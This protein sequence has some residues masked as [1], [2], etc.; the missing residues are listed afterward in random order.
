MRIPVLRHILCPLAHELLTSSSRFDEHPTDR[1]NAIACM[2]PY[3][4]ISA[5]LRESPTL[6]VRLRSFPLHLVQEVEVRL[7]EVVYAH[8]SVFSSAAVAS[9]LWVDGDV[10]EGTEMTTHTADFLHENLVVEPGLELSLPS[11][12]CRDVHGSLTSAQ[13]Y[14]LLDGAN[15]SAVQWCIRDIC[16]QDLESLS[17]HKL[18]SVSSAISR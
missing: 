15:S 18:Q 17:V 1:R 10:V 8:V 13:N 7:V 4:T 12:C 16:L 2:Q 9:A 14:V 11:R 3:R 5:I 6:Q